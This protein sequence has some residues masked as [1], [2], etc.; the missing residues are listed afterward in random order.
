MKSNEKIIWYK[1]GY[2]IMAISLLILISYVCYT[3]DTAWVFLGFAGTALSLVLSVLAILVTL[4]DVAGQKQQVVDITNSAIELKEI[5]EQ[6]KL[7]NKDYKNAMDSLI[8]DN[9]QS[10]FSSFEKRISLVIDQLPDEKK[11]EVKDEIDNLAKSINKYRNSILQYDNFDVFI[12]IPHE[13][14]VNDVSHL[15]NTLTS[16]G[17][18]VKDIINV[19]RNNKKGVEV[20]FSLSGDLKTENK[21][22][23]YYKQELEIRRLTKKILG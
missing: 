1:S 23:E 4:W 8:N 22:N 11:N 3:Q 20:L 10:Q 18:D 19:N 9:M 6:L 16:R 7:E 14:N 2:I 21:L 5:V 12:P 13:I 15:Y 17:I